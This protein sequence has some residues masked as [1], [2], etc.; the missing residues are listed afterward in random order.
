MADV[1]KAKDHTLGRFVG[2]KVLKQEFSE[3][4]NFVTKFRTEAQSAAGL[5]EQ[6][7]NLP[8]NGL[9]SFSV[10]KE[11][12]CFWDEDDICHIKLPGPFA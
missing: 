6:Y 7:V 12:S 2:I 9:V 1:Y 10:L 5:I 8:E 4:M 3:D 11:F